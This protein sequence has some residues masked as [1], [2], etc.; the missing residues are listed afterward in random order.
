MFKGI[1]VNAGKLERNDANNSVKT[2]TIPDHLAG[3]D[4]RKLYKS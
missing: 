2:T 4:A 1:E 3:H